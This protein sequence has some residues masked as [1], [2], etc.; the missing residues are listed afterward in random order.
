M[1][2]QTMAFFT[3]ASFARI[4]GRGSVAPRTCAPAGK[5]AAGLGVAAAAAGTT[6]ANC[7]GQSDC[8]KMVGVGVI[9]RAFGYMLGLQAVPIDN[10][11]QW[12][13]QD[14]GDDKNWKQR[15]TAEDEAK[16]GGT[17]PRHANNG[18]FS[19]VKGG[20]WECTPGK[21]DCTN[22]RKGSTET[23]Y[24]LP[25]RATLYD[26]D[27]NGE[28]PKF[29]ADLIPGTLHILP[30]GCAIRWEVTEKIRKIYLISDDAVV[31]N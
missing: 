31:A 4:I 27:A 16:Y 19:N 12:R 29:R 14:L 6:S 20:I 11:D 23:I 5:M 1:G 13:E 21:F 30:K 22:G 24:I 9:A 7:D 15:S 2:E 28:N 8:L 25:G 3:R 26:L 18:G 10:A 17:Q